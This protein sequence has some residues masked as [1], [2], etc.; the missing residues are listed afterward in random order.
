MAFKILHNK[1]HAIFLSLFMILNSQA[2]LERRIGILKIAAH[3][4]GAVVQIARLKCR[5]QIHIEAH[6]S[7]SPFFMRFMALLITHRALQATK[8]VNRISHWGFSGR[9]LLTQ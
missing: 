4:D 6:T 7:P 1:I 2:H 8:D 9:F 5:K 3:P